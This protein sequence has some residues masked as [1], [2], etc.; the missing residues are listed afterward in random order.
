MGAYTAFCRGPS[1]RKGLSRAG[2][3]G[4][5]PDAKRAPRPLPLVIKNCDAGN[6]NSRGS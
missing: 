6:L 4:Y 5:P 1:T 2:R 3:A